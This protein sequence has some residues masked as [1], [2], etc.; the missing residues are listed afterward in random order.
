M[1]L[2]RGSNAWLPCINLQD[3]S[4]TVD[5]SSRQRGVNLSQNFD[6]PHVGPIFR[7]LKCIFMILFAPR[8]V[9]FYCMQYEF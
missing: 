2:F 6:G 4:K 1:L 8:N 9:T 5:F 3:I 7:S